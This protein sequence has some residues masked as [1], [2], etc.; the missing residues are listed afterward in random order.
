MRT[1]RQHIFAKFTANFTS[2]E[3]GDQD[4]FLLLLQ[5]PPEVDPSYQC[6]DFL[7]ATRIGV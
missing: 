2:Q 7:A 3:F 5:F 4:C 6:K 1:I